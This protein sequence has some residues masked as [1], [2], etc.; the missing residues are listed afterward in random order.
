[1]KTIL[2]VS[3]LLTAS[4]VFGQGYYGSR[5]SEPQIYMPADHTAHASYA[6]MAQERGIGGGGSPTF[7]QGDRPASD[8]PQVASAPLGDTARELKKQHAQVK[9]AR[10][11]W[12]N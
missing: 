12:E 7:A 10:F 1:M 2:L 9:K 4:V 3:C 8:F 5:V 11:V 6:P